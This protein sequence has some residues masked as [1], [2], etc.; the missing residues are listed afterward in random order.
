MMKDESVCDATRS[1]L[2]MLHANNDSSNQNDTAETPKKHLGVRKRGVC[3]RR[4]ISYESECNETSSK[5]DKHFPS[6]RHAASYS[7]ELDNDQRHDQP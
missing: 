3:R 5:T 1:L 7:V 6:K 2:P 4:P